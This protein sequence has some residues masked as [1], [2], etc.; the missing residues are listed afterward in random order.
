MHTRVSR[1]CSF[2]FPGSKSSF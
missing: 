2:N 1:K